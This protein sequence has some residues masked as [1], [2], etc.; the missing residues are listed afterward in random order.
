M[1]YC[2]IPLVD[3]NRFDRVSAEKINQVDRFRIARIILQQ[4]L[5]RIVYGASS[6]ALILLI[7]H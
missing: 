4:R 3:V 5:Q 6:K 7:I 1:I 2:H